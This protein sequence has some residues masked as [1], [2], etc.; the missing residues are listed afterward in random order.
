MPKE[1]PLVIVTGLSGAGMSSALKSLED[2]GYE[3]L[4]NFPLILIPQLLEKK[5]DKPIAIGVDSRT[6]NFSAAK[7]KKAV[8]ENKATL[9]FITCKHSVLQKRFTETRRKH[10]LAQDR[11]VSDGINK[12]M[13]LLSPIRGEADLVIDTTELNIHDLRRMI[14]GHFSSDKQQ[15]LT[16][17][18]VSFGFRN[19]IPRDADIV[20]DVRFLK[21]PHW[22]AKLKPLTGKDKKIGAYI[23]KDESFEPFLKNFQNLLEPLLERYNHE[24]KSYL[25]IAI[26]C[27]GGKHRSVYTVEKLSRWFKDLKIKTNIKHRDIP[28]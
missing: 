15:R 10:P 12:E 23:E 3:V 11:P 19:G 24:G 6:R 28:D 9:V 4:D 26:G 17:T 7:L 18:L 25:T 5:S 22:D 16:V 20:M 21:N 27:T 1:E 8:K 14:E 2:I 13:E